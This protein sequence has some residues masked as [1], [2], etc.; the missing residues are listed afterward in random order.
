MARGRDGN[1]Y[2]VSNASDQVL[3]FDGTTGAPLGV[4]ASA[5]L[6]TPCDLAFGPDGDLYVTSRD[7][8]SVLRYAGATGAL[9]GTFTSGAAL[10]SPIGLAFGPDGNLYVSSL[11]DHQVL[12]YAGNTGVF[13]DV[14]VTPHSGGLIGPTM[15][16]FTPEPGALALLALLGALMGSRMR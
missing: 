1:L 7:T 13:V 14:F 11:T 15:L 4:F 2:V 16:A 5:G 9:L 8:G 12:R 6:D 3:R 10:N